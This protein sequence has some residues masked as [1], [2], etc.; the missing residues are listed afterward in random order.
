MV[1]QIQFNFLFLFRIEDSELKQ[2]IAT[3]Q[4]KTKEP[5]VKALGFFKAPK[6]FGTLLKRYTDSIYDNA[7]EQ[8]N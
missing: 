6:P 8:P 4:S 1:A 3:E 5:S 7:K 2:T